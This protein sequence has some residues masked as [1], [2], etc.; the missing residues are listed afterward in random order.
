[1]GKAINSETAAIYTA[2]VDK[3]QQDIV[4]QAI[5][6]LDNRIRHGDAMSSPD[7]TRNYLRLNLADELAEVFCCL[8]LDNRNRVISFDRLFNGTIDGASV[9]PREVVRAAINH[10]AAAVIFAHNHPSGVA[11]PSSAD[12]QITKRLKDALA[13]IDVRTLD[14]IVVGDD[15]VSFAERGLI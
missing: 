9:Y 13:L 14:H 6:I 12:K 1:M 5:S 4:N 8:F 11:E 3:E 15:C 2:V 10:N 7:D